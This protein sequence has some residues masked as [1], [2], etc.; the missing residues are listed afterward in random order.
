MAEPYQTAGSPTSADL[1]TLV[2]VIRDVARLHRLNDADAQDFGQ[3]VHLRFIERR[4]DVFARFDGRSTLRSYLT[5]VVTRLLLDWRNAMYGKWRPCAAARRLGTA[6]VELDR[7]INRDGYSADEATELL[8]R[9]MQSSAAHLRDL[10]DRLPRRARRRF[11]DDGCLA[12]T[13][14]EVFRDPIEAREAQLAAR[15]SSVALARACRELP[16][17]ERRMIALRY[18][19]SMSVQQIGRLLDVNPKQ[20]YRRFDRTMRQLR[21]AIAKQSSDPT[22]CA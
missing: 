3:S 2:S 6:A 14:I 22:P 5:V 13:A 20:L 11:V 7:L 17:D 18:H 12:S 9:E 16:A 19:R 15:R 8:M 4:Y 21:A 1:N 10:A